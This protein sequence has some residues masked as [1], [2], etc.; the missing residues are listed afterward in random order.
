MSAL[1]TSKKSPSVKIVIG[2]VKIMMSGLMNTFK[3]AK[4][5]ATHTEVRKL[6]TWIPGKMCA[7]SMTMK[8]ETKVLMAKL[9]IDTDDDMLL[10]Y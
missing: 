9:E 7:K 10:I 1:M 6:S 2:I 3:T 4:T 5:I 8:A